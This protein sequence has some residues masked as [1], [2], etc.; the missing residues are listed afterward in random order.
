[1]DRISLDKVSLES[2]RRHRFLMKEEDSE[3]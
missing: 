3:N 1:M 2:S